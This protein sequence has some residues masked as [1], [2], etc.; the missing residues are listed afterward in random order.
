MVEGASEGD[1][2][3][4]ISDITRDVEVLSNKLF[5]GIGQFFHPKFFMSL[6]HVT[7]AV[8]A[9]NETSLGVSDVNTL[10]LIK[11][12]SVSLLKN[13]DLNRRNVDGRTMNHPFIT[14]NSSI[15]IFIFHGFFSS[16]Q[17][18]LIFL[19]DVGIL[20]SALKMLTRLKEERALTNSKL[21]ISQSV[22][23]CIGVNRIL[24]IAVLVLS[25]DGDINKIDEFFID[26][27]DVEGSNGIGDKIFITSLS[28]LSILIIE[29]LSS[30]QVEG[31]FTCK[32]E[33]FNKL[34]NLLPD[35]REI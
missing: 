34:N 11:R 2:L 35:I 19:K 13:S 4:L 26:V 21:E 14:S 15:A 25:E 30:S 12:N 28:F 10:I 22:L 3:L 16:Q 20:N 31:S 5:F 24:N 17:E 33:A 1:D 32:G 27:D 7:L 6:E 23:A 8:F 18:G 9:P 29:G